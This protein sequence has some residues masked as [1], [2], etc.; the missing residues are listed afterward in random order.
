MEFGTQSKKIIAEL[1]VVLFTFLRGFLD[2]LEDPMTPLRPQR[3][4]VVEL[5]KS[6]PGSKIGI[7]RAGKYIGQIYL[8]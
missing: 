5:K 6:L 8:I 1:R 7:T 3:G 2:I 4:F